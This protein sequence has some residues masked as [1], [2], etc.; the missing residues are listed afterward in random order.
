MFFESESRSSFEESFGTGGE[1]GPTNSGLVP[2]PKHFGA[3][4]VIKIGTL[5]AQNREQNSQCD[6][7]LMRIHIHIFLTVGAEAAR[8]RPQDS[9]RTRSTLNTP[10]HTPHPTIRVRGMDAKG[11]FFLGV[12]FLLSPSYSYE[13]MQCKVNVQ[14]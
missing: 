12:K 11:I 10:L 1:S 5:S 13:K 6:M 3:P 14:T 7:P 9:H 8:P 4:N 2:V